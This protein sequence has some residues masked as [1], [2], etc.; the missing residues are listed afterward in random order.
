MIKGWKKEL[1][2][3]EEEEM[4]SFQRLMNWDECLPGAKNSYS[5]SSSSFIW[6]CASL[7]S[8]R[9]EKEEESPDQR[10]L[11]KREKLSISS[12]KPVST[13]KEW[14]AF[15]IRIRSGEVGTV[16]ETT[17]TAQ[18]LFFFFFFFLFL[19]TPVSHRE[20]N[21]SNWRKVPVNTWAKRRGEKRRSS[22]KETNRHID[23][24]EHG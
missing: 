8:S 5:S 11:P 9:Q 24:G 10:R 2:L 3:P 16:T 21:N 14:N 1:R 17:T 13:A 19:F 15:K 12:G 23:Y 20:S 4:S 7:F 18:P 22:N 6:Q